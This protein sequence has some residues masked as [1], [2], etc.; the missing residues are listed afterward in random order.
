M[1]CITVE[2][3]VE[4]GLQIM[5][6]IYAILINRFTNSIIWYQYDTYFFNFFF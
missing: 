1:H 2:V 4:E 3:L 5:I 6:L